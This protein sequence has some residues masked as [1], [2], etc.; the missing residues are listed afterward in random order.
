MSTDLTQ[1][2]GDYIPWADD[3][4]DVYERAMAKRDQMVYEALNDRFEAEGGDATIELMKA[5]K[6]GDPM[7]ESM[8]EGGPGS[9]I[10]GHTTVKAD[11]KAPHRLT[12]D[13]YIATLARAP[14]F[15]G[16]K[17]IADYHKLAVKKA[18]IAGHVVDD[19]VMKDYPE[20]KEKAED[21]KKNP[22][23]EGLSDL[24]R[25]ILEGWENYP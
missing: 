25:S 18:L 6:L 4:E 13:K 7:V 24:Q 20:W 5:G 14:G 12:R 16:K 21:N 10:D 23:Q 17:A 22:R 2:Q 11:L 9:G 19:E 15:P 3:E 1:P 8:Q